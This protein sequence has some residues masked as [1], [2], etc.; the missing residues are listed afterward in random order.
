MT[1]KYFAA[2]NSSGGFV[3][4]FDDIFAPDGIDRTYIIKGGS[5]TGK[6]TLMKRIASRG[7]EDGWQCEYF[8]CSSDPSSLDGILLRSSDGRSLA[9][10]DGTAPH[11]RDPRYPGA[12]EEI[13]N[14]GEYWDS[15]QLRAHRD[16]ITAL[17][18]KK[19][20]CFAA[21]YEYLYAAGELN[22]LIRSETAR[23]LLTDKMG[24]AAER[25][26]VQAM[27]ESHM[28]PSPGEKP[29]IAIRAVS[30]LSTDG[31]VHFDTYAQLPG[32]VVAVNDLY[33]S[34]PFFFD[35]LIDVGQRLGLSMVRAPSP[36]EPS[37]TEALRFPEL[38]LSVVTAEG[39]LPDDLRLV[40]M[41]RFLDRDALRQSGDRIR[42]R[43]LTRTVREL[44]DGALAKLSEVRTI[45][46]QVEKIYI[47]AM[48]F[49]FVDCFVSDLTSRLFH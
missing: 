28:R 6:S 8:Y 32:R 26:L 21:A 19:S 16:E 47:A 38:S 44:T 14:L 39:E 22:R 7:C 18:M 42:R 45:H 33:G 35:A 15:D 2:A 5:G 3:S 37:L 31:A 48:D 13:I 40:N 1:E 4:W 9:V 24:R 49:T 30:A 23:Y 20:S 17:C 29:K 34:A 46:A 27:H 36:L 43:I 10:L 11:T 25:L 12:A 41:A